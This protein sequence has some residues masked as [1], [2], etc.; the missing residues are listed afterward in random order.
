MNERGEKRKKSLVILFL[1]EFLVV[2]AFLISAGGNYFLTRMNADKRSRLMIDNECRQA[3]DR[4]DSDLRNIA[5][6]GYT[7]LNMEEVQ[8]LQVYYY[9][10]ISKDVYARN[11]AI[12]RVTA[13]IVSLVSYYDIIDS[14]AVYIQPKD[15]ELFYNPMYTFVGDPYRKGVMDEA[16][17]NHA[18]E[19]LYTDLLRNANG[20][21]YITLSLSE[22]N[23]C[24]VAFLLDKECL[25]EKLKL[26]SAAGI[27]TYLAEEGGRI[28]AI[29]TTESVAAD[30]I[31]QMQ[32]MHEPVLKSGTIKYYTK[33]ANALPFYVELD[34]SVL[35]NTLGVYTTFVVI[36]LV[37]L[38]GV[39]VIFILI[40]HRYFNHPVGVM[41]RAM[42]K[43]GQGNFNVLIEE[44]ISTDIQTLYDGFNMMVTSVNGYIEDNYR[45]KIMRTE[46]EF[47]A[48]QA[49]I[50]PHFLYNCFAHIRGMC[51]SGDVETVER[52]TGRLSQMFLYIT[53][54]AAAIVTLKDEAENMLCYLEIQTIRFGDRVELQVQ[55]LPAEYER[56]RVPK[57]CLQ[58]IVENAYKYVFSKIE[59]GGVLRVSYS[60]KEGK[61]YVTIEDNGIS[62]T[63]EQ[64]E[65][66]Y[67]SL[68]SAEETS[69][70][71][72]VARRLRYY[73]P[74]EGDLKLQ[75]SSL[76]GLSVTVV[77]SG[78][79][80]GE[81]RDV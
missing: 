13:Q 80:Q 11:E 23:N 24:I 53:R 61:L 57:L 6:A 20:N 18:Y 15:E 63:D 74:G 47:K 56:V 33:I 4:V 62:I 60:E 7:L 45:Q 10:L 31:W 32:R 67:Q 8:R 51:K 66:M 43:V 41:L 44:N 49:Q 42:K 58:P 3:I 65:Y 48:L 14:C 71:I 1:I 55:P 72:N 50:N 21:L 52:M 29:C 64:I 12:N 38:F 75:R 22:E 35:D 69:G 68:G 77:L 26:V 73:A 5:S 17:V 16:I 37:M 34:A 9:D 46:S 81:G 78:V 36:A 27:S 59:E 19:P 28:Y 79:I 70:L 76:G 2:V 40:F 30:G 39:S 54:S 25:V